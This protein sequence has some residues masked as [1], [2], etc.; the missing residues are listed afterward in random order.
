MGV[1]I[2]VGVGFGGLMKKDDLIELQNYLFP[3]IIPHTW[4]LILTEHTC[5]LSL[6]NSGTQIQ[7]HASWKICTEPEEI[8]ETELE[9]K[10]NPGWVSSSGWR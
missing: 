5:A 9:Q 10:I 2:G 6:G 3:L 1:G 7:H 4:L 8:D